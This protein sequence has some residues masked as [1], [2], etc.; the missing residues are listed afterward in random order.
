MSNSYLGQIVMFGGNFA[1]QNF[2]FCNGQLLSI[3]QNTALFS[4][5]GTTYGGDGIQTFALP[6]LRSRLPIHE[7]QGTGLSLYTIGQNGGVPSVTLQTGQ[8]PSHNHSLNATTAN[9][10]ANVV[11]GNV[12]AQPTTGT[13]PIF[14]AQAA[15]GVSPT[16]VAL[17]GGVCG[18]AGQN[19]P[20][21]NMMPS[22]CITFLIATAGPF[23]VRN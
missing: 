15:S 6:D 12:P 8:I 10:S 7:G 5:L 11:N 1:P 18:Q 13:P 22:L 4:L 21:D 19:L 20:H 23:P 9:A 3:S 14:Y 2:A 17:A 16:V